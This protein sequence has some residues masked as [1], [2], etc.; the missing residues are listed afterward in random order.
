MAGA[1]CQ[2][3][4]RGIGRVELQ[5]D[6]CPHQISP[7]VEGRIISMRST[8]P[9]W[10]PRTILAKL[11]KERDDAPSRSAIY[12]CLVRQKLIQPQARRRAPADMDSSCSSVGMGMHGDDRDGHTG[13]DEHAHGTGHRAYCCT[14]VGQAQRRRLC[15]GLGLAPMSLSVRRAARFGVGVDV[16]VVRFFGARRPFGS[17]VGH[18]TSGLMP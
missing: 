16:G 3:W 7:V 1:L 12:R 8:H 17:D 2:G 6:R 10:G 13:S 15:P 14:R 11:R 5:A 4:N 18:C 9:G